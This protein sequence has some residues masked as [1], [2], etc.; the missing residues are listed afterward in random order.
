M[1]PLLH[2][3]KFDITGK[4]L[5]CFD[6]EL[7]VC[8]I[9]IKSSRLVIKN[10]KIFWGPYAPNRFLKRVKV[11][12]VKHIT[13]MLTAIAIGACPPQEHNAV[14]GA[15]LSYSTVMSGNSTSALLHMTTT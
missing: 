4:E 11:S 6:S 1:S 7:L 9:L 10:L 14:E 5:I 13:E 2:A 15:E 3:F 8:N 12:N